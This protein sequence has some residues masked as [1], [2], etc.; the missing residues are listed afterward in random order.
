MKQTLTLLTALLLAPMAAR[1][2]LVA[3]LI[4]YATGAEVSYADRAEIARIVESTAAKQHGV[5]S[6]IHALAE[7]ILFT[8]GN[9]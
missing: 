3:H 5:R 8:P 6:L 1:A 9:P 7:S 2:D 4:R